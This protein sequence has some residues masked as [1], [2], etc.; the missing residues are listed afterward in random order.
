[1]RCV[2]LIEGCAECEREG[3]WK[4]KNGH[5]CGEPGERFVNFCQLKFKQRGRDEEYHEIS[6]RP[7]RCDQCKSILWDR[8]GYDVMTR[9][10]CP[11]KMCTQTRCPYCKAIWMEAGPVN[12]PSCGSFYVPPESLRRMR[13]LYKARRRY[14]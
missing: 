9:N 6:H 1:M 10:L 8:M 2:A 7:V 11:A 5:E 14:W 12:C 13:R 3:D 4:E